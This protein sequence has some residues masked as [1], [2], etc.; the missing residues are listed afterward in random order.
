MNGHPGTNSAYI[1]CLDSFVLPLETLR[2]LKSIYS[3]EG[4]DSQHEEPQKAKKAQLGAF[5][6]AVHLLLNL[7]FE[8]PCILCLGR[9][10]LL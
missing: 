4:D 10:H 8:D 1:S 7:H 6:Q 2:R 3:G 5:T 9:S